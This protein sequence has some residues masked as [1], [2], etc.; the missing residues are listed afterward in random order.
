MSKIITHF[1]KQEKT[2]FD[3]HLGIVALKATYRIVPYNVI[4]YAVKPTNIKG[5]D[6]FVIHHAENFYLKLRRHHYC[7]TTDLRL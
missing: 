5:T 6:S 1:H 7:C 2:V 3:G 4:V